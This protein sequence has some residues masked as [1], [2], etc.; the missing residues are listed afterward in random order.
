MADYQLV[1]EWRRHGEVTHVPDDAVNLTVRPVPDRHGAYV[2]YL[3]PFET[4]V[5]AD[6]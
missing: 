5:L 2:T 3:V 1:S 6:R 4:V